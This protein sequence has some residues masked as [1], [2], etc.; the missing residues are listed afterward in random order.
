M[1]LTLTQDDLDAIAIAVWSQQLPLTFDCTLSVG[2]SNGTLFS[3]TGLWLE[4]C[5]IF[6]T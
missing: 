4:A 1:A 3:M 5:T 2:G 6:K